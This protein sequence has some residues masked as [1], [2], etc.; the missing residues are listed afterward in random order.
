[1]YRSIGVTSWVLYSQKGEISFIFCW[2]TKAFNS[3]GVFFLFICLF[4]CLWI[5]KAAQS[6][7]F[8]WKEEAPLSPVSE[9]H[10]DI[11]PGWLEIEERKKPQ[12]VSSNSPKLESH[13]L[14]VKESYLLSRQVIPADLSTAG[15][16]PAS[17]TA[18]ENWMFS[19]KLITLNKAVTFLYS[20]YC[21]K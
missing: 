3:T 13:M 8:W 18:T 9:P 4:I 10:V 14:K 21:P 2:V 1:M 11:P 6:P 20:S 17:R 5:K 16:S 7:H 19:N 15:C 12:S